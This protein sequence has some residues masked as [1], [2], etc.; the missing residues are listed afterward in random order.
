[1]TLLAPFE[2]K[3]DKE[4][5]DFNYEVDALEDEHVRREVHTTKV[6]L[7]EDKDGASKADK[8]DGNYTETVGK[9]NKRT[10]KTRTRAQPVAKV[11]PKPAQPFQTQAPPTLPTQNTQGTP[12]NT[13]QAK[14]EAKKSF[15]FLGG[16]DKS[17]HAES[18]FPSLHKFPPLNNR[19]PKLPSALV[20]EKKQ[21]LLFSQ[22][23]ASVTKK[24]E[25]APESLYPF[26]NNSSSQPPTITPAFNNIP[27]PSYE[28]IGGGMGAFDH[29][30]EPVG[31]SG[32]KDF[33]LEKSTEQKGFNNLFKVNFN[34]FA[35]GEFGRSIEPQEMP[36]NL[37]Q[38]TPKYPK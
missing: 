1:M 10:R 38:P 26:G 31:F 3:R 18:P 9:N 37:A 30:E 36:R 6:V 7:D 22:I 34:P 27:K 2:D 4:V 16:D 8:N 21:P 19:S 23:G 33:M 35:S 5:Q 28:S 17:D 11:A 32:S 15:D 14:R 13:I 25:K 12:Q 20:A 24:E 29:I